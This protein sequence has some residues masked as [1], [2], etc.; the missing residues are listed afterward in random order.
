VKPGGLLIVDD[1]SLC[2]ARTLRR[3]R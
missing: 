3:G 2:E 1:V